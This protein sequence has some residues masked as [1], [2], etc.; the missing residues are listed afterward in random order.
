MTA[1][2]PMTANS[3]MSAPVK[4]R[5]LLP[6]LVDPDVELGCVK[7]SAF[8][9]VDGGTGVVFDEIDGGSQPL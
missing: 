9:D 5:L 7:G 8:D 2:A 3:S 4:G 6:L 1:P